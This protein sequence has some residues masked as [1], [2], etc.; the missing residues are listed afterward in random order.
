MLTDEG[1]AG[2]DGLAP[3][4]SEPEPVADPA[5][6]DALEPIDP[7][8]P[9]VDDEPSAPVAEG[10]NEELVDDA[11]PTSARDLLEETSRTKPDSS[12][13]GV[14]EPLEV[15]VVQ[16][17]GVGFDADTS[18]SRDLADVE[19]ASLTAFGSGSESALGD[20][21]VPD[22]AAFEDLAPE[23]ADIDDGF[24]ALESF[25]PLAGDPFALPDVEQGLSHEFEGDVI[26]EPAI[27]LDIDFD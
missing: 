9:V 22:D 2:V 7:E 25:D 10:A 24:R 8:E 21:I 4:A 14:P 23:K 27:G 19:T 3:Q 20:V 1:D 13:D 6:V 12:D 16:P 5:T 11:K 17:I 15:D 26:P 18:A